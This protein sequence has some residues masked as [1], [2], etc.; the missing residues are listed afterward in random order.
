MARTKPS[1]NLKGELKMNLS[2]LEWWFRTPKELIP[3]M[4]CFWGL[5]AI[6][7]KF[8]IAFGALGLVFGAITVVTSTTGKDT[9]V[10][11]GAASGMVVAIVISFIGRGIV[12]VAYY[13]AARRDSG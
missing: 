9:P 13:M 8:I 7:G 6:L 1:Q 5:V 4:G 12:A 2:S 11:L 3:K 10:I